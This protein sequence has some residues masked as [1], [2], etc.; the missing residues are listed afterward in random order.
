MM[1]NQEAISKLLAV[2][3]QEAERGGASDAFFATPDDMVAY[4]NEG[5]AEQVKADNGLTPAEVAD[6]YVVNTDSVKI[7]NGQ[8]KVVNP[9]TVLVSQ[10]YVYGIFIDDLAN[11]DLAQA[12]DYPETR[13]AARAIVDEWKEAMD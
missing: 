13:R 11:V 1:T 7:E 5:T 9:D 6:G 3:N 4:I 2:Q 10:P 8:F 12:F